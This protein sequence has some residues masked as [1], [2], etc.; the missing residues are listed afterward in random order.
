MDQSK[1]RLAI[2]QSKTEK[3]VLIQR[4]C[5]RY[6]SVLM[7]WNEE[8]MSK[9]LTMTS[10]FCPTAHKN[11]AT[12][13]SYSDKTPAALRFGVAGRRCKTFSTWHLNSIHQSREEIRKSYKQWELLTFATAGEE[14]EEGLPGRF[15]PMEVGSC[16]PLVILVFLG[17]CPL[18]TWEN[19]QNH[20]QPIFLQP[21]HRSLNPTVSRV[22]AG[23]RMDKR[24][25]LPKTSKTS[26]M[27]KF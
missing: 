23:C 21:Q 7:R 27:G 5:E 13:L 26:N 2:G 1:T 9:T 24:C 8:T 10:Y 14:G 19:I 4:D 20:F 15:E 17:K 22:G 6:G 16:T 12:K 3:V 11:L 25:G 18:K